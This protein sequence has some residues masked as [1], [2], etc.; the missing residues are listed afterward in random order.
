[1]TSP[2]AAGPA[3]APECGPTTLRSAFLVGAPRCGTTFL[4]K[5]LARHPEVCFS[6][7]KETHFFVR[8]AREL[9]EAHWRPELLRRYFAALEP[10]H[11]LI[12]EG[13]PLALRD[14]E[15]IARLLRF[16]P[17]TRFVVAVRNPVEM[18][19]SFHAR[20][21]YLLEEDERDFAA[22]WAL[23]AARARGLRIPSRCRDVASLQYRAMASLGTQLARLIDQAGRERV[24][25]V[26]FDDLVAE[27]VRIYRRLLAFL[28]LPDDGRERFSR[29]NENRDFRHEWAQAF[30]TNPPR[31]VAA[32]LE[33]RQ[34]RGK[35]RPE[36]VRRLRRRI[37]RWNTRRAERHALSPAMR[38]LLNR[39]LASEREQLE[40]LLG[41]DLSHWR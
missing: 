36:W 12:V 3:L 5:I 4:A 9:A 31:P 1:M 21:V 35:A 17:A 16:D 40:A 26:V 28:E 24:H 22:A 14:P 20:L 25:V 33:R 6:K 29:K 15:A 8:D 34:A 30:V 2:L 27:P 37:K 11:R 23:Q 18:I 19:H 32:W 39:E 10:R 13:S 7:P 38:S 41:R